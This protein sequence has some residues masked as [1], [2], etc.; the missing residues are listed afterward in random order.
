MK[1]YSS[2]LVR[3]WVIQSTAEQSNEEKVVFDIEHIQ[4]GEHLRSA[5]PAEALAWML[6]AAH[7]DH[8]TAA[9]PDSAEA[10]PNQT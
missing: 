6:A 5:S 4:R 2:F 9:A 7:A 1:R 8:T 10:E 3:C